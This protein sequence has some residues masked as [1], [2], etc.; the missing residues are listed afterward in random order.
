MGFTAWHKMH[1][2]MVISEGYTRLTYQAE[3]GQLWLVAV[4]SLFLRKL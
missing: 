4:Y 1:S 3:C 2:V